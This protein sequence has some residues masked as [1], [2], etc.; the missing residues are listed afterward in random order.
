VNGIG[1]EHGNVLRGDIILFYNQNY[2]PEMK[3]FAMR[4]ASQ[5]HENDNLLLSPLPVTGRNIVSP[6]K[7]NGFPLFIHPLE[8]NMSDLLESPNSISYIVS[9]PSK[10][11]EN[12]V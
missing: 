8:K 9:S 12:Y 10:V 6:K 1:Q 11:S 4:F 2:V 7:I 5:G 3:E